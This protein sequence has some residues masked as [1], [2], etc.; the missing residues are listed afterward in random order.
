FGAMAVDLVAGDLAR[1]LA[2][3][4]EGDRLARAEALD[5]YAS[6]R[7]LDQHEAALIELFEASAALLGA[8]RWVR[9]HF[10]EGRVFEHPQTVARG[11]E[12]GLTRLARLAAEASW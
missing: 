9:W 10:V 3:W 6:I 11:L 8:G 4:L 1:L 2:E 12:R 7:P 5:A